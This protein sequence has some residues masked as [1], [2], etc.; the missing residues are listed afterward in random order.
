[1]LKLE[2]LS[3]QSFDTCIKLIKAYRCAPEPR[4]FCNE[5]VHLT[6]IDDGSTH[7]YI[8]DGMENL[9]TCMYRGEQYEQLTPVIFVDDYYDY[10]EV[11]D[12]IDQLDIIDIRDYEVEVCNRIESSFYDCLTDEHKA[13]VDKI[14]ESALNNL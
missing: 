6:T 7:V 9:W 3:K 11:N 10:Y 1:M 12:Y 13:K 4:A 14:I 5:N 8:E 2:E